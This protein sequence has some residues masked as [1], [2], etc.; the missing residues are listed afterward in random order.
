MGGQASHLRRENLD[1]Q[2][3]HGWMGAAKLIESSGG[4][5]QGLD[6][7]ESHNGRGPLVPRPEQCLFPEEV[8]RPEHRQ[9]D[10]LTL[11]RRD[12]HRD[13]PFGEQ[14]KGSAG[15]PLMD[16]HLVAHVGAP[17]GRCQ[18]SRSIILG[19]VRQDRPLHRHLTSEVGPAHAI[20]GQ[21]GP[22]GRPMWGG[23]PEPADAA[24][25]SCAVPK[26]PDRSAARTFP[27]R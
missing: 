14:V 18:H 11:G 2:M 12:P 5:R 16:D 6:W 23:C 7:F 27:A 3:L 25:R 13:P 26:V 1:E 15:V 19:E 4:H 17:C 9:R 22:C 21:H 10:D 24:A 8:P 20:A